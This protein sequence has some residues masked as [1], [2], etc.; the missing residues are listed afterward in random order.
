MNYSVI[1]HTLRRNQELHDTIMRMAVNIGPGEAEIF[2]E[3]FELRCKASQEC[4]AGADD[5]G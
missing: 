5:A 4:N 2:S 3:G 1:R